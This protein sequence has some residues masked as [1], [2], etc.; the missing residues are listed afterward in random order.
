LVAGGLVAVA[1]YLLLS[2]V[3]TGGGLVV[4][5]LLVSSVGRW[6][7]HLN[8]WFVGQRTATGNRVTGD[9]TLLADTEGVAVVAGAVAL[10]ALIRRRGR[11]AAFLAIGLGVELAGFVTTDYLVGRPRPG[12]RHLGSTPS[13]SSWPSGHVAATVVLYGGIA[14]IVMWVTRRLVAR[15]VAWT[16]AALLTACVGLSRVYRGDHHPSDVI[17][18]LGL[19]AGALLVA[20][21]ALRAWARRDGP[22]P[23]RPEPDA[24]ERLTGS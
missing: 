15:I 4:T 7:D 6:D 13:T 14:L 11:L 18:G 1:G 8:A 17:A 2:S 10:I 24:L 21:L 5:H 12:V 16:A 22:E 20:A 19:G 3:L 23:A 9:F